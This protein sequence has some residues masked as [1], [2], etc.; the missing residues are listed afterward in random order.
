VTLIGSIPALIFG[1]SSGDVPKTNAPPGVKVRVRLRPA[2]FASVYFKTPEGITEWYVK[3]E[4]D[5]YR[6]PWLENARGRNV[7]RTS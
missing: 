3:R 7:R 6:S 4:T 2:D 5:G 1:V